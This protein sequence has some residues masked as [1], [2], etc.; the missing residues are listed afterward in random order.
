[1]GDRFFSLEKSWMVDVYC[2]WLFLL[3]SFPVPKMQGYPVCKSKLCRE[4]IRTAR[5][6]RFR[7]GLV[8]WGSSVHCIRLKEI[9]FPSV[10]ILQLTLV[11]HFDKTGNSIIVLKTVS[12]ISIKKII[13]ML[14][15]IYIKTE[16]PWKNDINCSKVVN[17]H[18]AFHQA[19][20]SLVTILLLPDGKR[21]LLKYVM[22]FNCL[23]GYYKEKN[24]Q[25]CSL[26]WN[27]T[28]VGSSQG[29][30]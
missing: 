27:V 26:W 30:F 28:C 19:K 1:M 12:M 6:D 21:N 10:Y 8:W 7:G 18:H 4:K 11:F 25:E 9:L 3:I 14:H 15:N 22:N 5:F 20:L 17:I 24:Q 23:I 16:F 13:G 2:N 29:A